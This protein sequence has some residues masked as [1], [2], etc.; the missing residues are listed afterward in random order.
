M[1][2]PRQMNLFPGD[3][4]TRSGRASFPGAARGASRT[5]CLL[6]ANLVHSL[7]VPVGMLCIV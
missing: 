2:K 7:A 3:A 4:D 6:L 5:D 1:A